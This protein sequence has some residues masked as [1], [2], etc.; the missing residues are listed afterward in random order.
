MFSLTKPRQQP[1]RCSPHV[2]HSFLH[3]SQEEQSKGI[4]VFMRKRGHTVDEFL[5]LIEYLTH[6]HV[7]EVGHE[8]TIRILDPHPNSSANFDKAKGSIH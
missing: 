5:Y 4:V 8:V 2:D 6:H 1:W 7:V 3:P